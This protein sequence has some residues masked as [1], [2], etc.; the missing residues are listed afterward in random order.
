MFIPTQEQ[1]N[2][3]RIE[4]DV[5]QLAKEQDSPEVV[6]DESINEC[7]ELSLD[8]RVVKRKELIEKLVSMDP[9]EF[10]HGTTIRLP[11]KVVAALMEKLCTLPDNERPIASKH[12]ER[13]ANQYQNELVRNLLKLA[14]Q[15]GYISTWFDFQVI[16]RYARWMC[17][18]N[19]T[20]LSLKNMTV[21]ERKVVTGYAKWISDKF[22]DWIKSRQA[23]SQ[24]TP[25]LSS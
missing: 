3:L 15:Q 25:S 10:K 16:K 6:E 17:F 5:V 24:H 18:K 11:A 7:A 21:S 12:L 8:E 20:S 22:S 19:A 9:S 23:T 1:L 14:I 2:R 13:A 4:S